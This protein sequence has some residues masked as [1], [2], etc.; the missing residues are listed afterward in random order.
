MRYESI[1]KREFVLNIYETARAARKD[2]AQI[3][4][5][6][7]KLKFATCYQFDVKFFETIPTMPKFCVMQS[8]FSRPEI[9][10]TVRSPLQS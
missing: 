5:E 7:R 6:L 10:R 8:I 3:N 2:I 9:W 4:K 1:F